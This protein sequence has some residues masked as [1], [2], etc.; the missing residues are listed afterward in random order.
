MESYPKINSIIDEYLWAKEQITALEG[1]AAHSSIH[2]RT[3]DNIRHTLDHVLVGLSLTGSPDNNPE[4]VA[5]QFDEAYLH[6]LNYAPNAA[7]YLA[8]RSLKNARGAIASAGFFGKTENANKLYQRALDNYNMARLKRTESPRE[9]VGLFK[10]SI[11]DAT[12]AYMATERM[13]WS[14]RVALWALLVSVIGLMLQV[15]GLLDHIR[16]F[17]FGG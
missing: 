11:E 2:A 7:E 14:L 10:L 6:I 9:A 5:G 8:G 13:P 17:V 1:S 3:V 12:K 4:K 15:L 16:S